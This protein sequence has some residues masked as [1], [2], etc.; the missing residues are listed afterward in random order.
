MPRGPFPAP[1]PIKLGTYEVK[2]G[3]I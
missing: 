3:S 2:E 1:I